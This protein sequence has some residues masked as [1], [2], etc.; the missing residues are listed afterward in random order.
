MSENINEPEIALKESI[1]ENESRKTPVNEPVEVKTVKIKESLVIS[2]IIT[3]EPL[4]AFSDETYACDRD[5]AIVLAQ[6]MSNK[7]RD[8]VYKW[9]ERLYSYDII[10]INYKIYIKINNDG[11]LKVPAKMYLEDNATVKFLPSYLF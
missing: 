2:N 11:V 10:I 5:Y 1:T 9:I 7:D 4:S 6:L 8:K 3:N